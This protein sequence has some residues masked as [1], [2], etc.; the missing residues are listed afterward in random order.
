MLL[1]VLLG[2]RTRRCFGAVWAGLSERVAFGCVCPSVSLSPVAVQ[3]G[4]VSPAVVVLLGAAPWLPP[5]RLAFQ[6]G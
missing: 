3:G 1:L 4:L 6:L 5:R 2:W